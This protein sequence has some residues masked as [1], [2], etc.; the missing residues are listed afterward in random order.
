V[1]TTTHQSDLSGTHSALFLASWNLKLL[2]TLAAIPHSRRREQGG[3]AAE[4]QKWKLAGF[5]ERS[6]QRVRAKRSSNCKR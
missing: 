4:P 6:L 2:R 1:G 3:D 5:W